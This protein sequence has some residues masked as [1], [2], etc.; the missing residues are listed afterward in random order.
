MFTIYKVFQTINPLLDVWTLH[1]AACGHWI[2]PKI[3]DNTLYFIWK[4][5]C[6]GGVCRSWSYFVIRWIC[7]SWQQILHI[8]GFFFLSG[9][10]L[11]RPGIK[12][13]LKF[14]PHLIYYNCAMQTVFFWDSFLIAW[15][16][17]NYYS[18]V[19]KKGMECAL[20][21][22]RAKICLSLQ[23]CMSASMLMAVQKVVEKYE[24]TQKWKHVWVSVD[25]CGHACPR[26]NEHIQE[27]KKHHI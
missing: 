2:P 4:W 20:G 1:H 21:F 13:P 22:T 5:I 18:C 3:K 7:E 25:A 8:D 10:G 27:T 9:S 16:W 24:K 12:E 26:R 14:C 11:S 17:W 23:R 6:L 19:I 15:H